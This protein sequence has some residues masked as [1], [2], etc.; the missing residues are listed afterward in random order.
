MRGPSPGK[1]MTARDAVHRFVPD[2][3]SIGMG[4]QNLGRVPMALTHEIVRQGKG[5]L[6][7]MGCNLSIAM[8][9]LVGAGLVSRTE[10]G[11]GNLERFGTTFRWRFAIEEGRLEHRDYSH[12]AMVSRFLAGEM[13]LPFMPTK[14]LLGS[15]ILNK[16]LDGPQ[17]YAIIQNPWDSEEPVA[18]LP[19]ATPDVAIVHVQRADEMGNVVIEGFAAHEPE[20]VRA[21]KAVIVSCEELVSSE[22]TRR[23]PELTTIPYIHVSGVVEQPFGAHPTSVY[24]Y[25]DFDGEHITGYQRCAR[26]GGQAYQDYLEHYILGCETFEDYL[27]RVGGV[28]KLHGLRQAMLRMV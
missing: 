2:G 6:T 21:A 17:G 28:K 7:L 23:H 11:T 8:D 16:H 25:Y 14:S 9:I 13:G 20:M 24:R 22:D 12:L 26:E 4:G 19:S 3:C 5:R 27:E 18:L 15:D 10:S 1:V